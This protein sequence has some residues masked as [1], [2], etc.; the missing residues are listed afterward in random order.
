[1]AHEVQ[2]DFGEDVFNQVMNAGRNDATKFSLMFRSLIYEILT[3]QHMVELRDG[4]VY[5]TPSTYTRDK[6]SGE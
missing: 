6:R 4:K 5:T 1:M 2:T 3:K